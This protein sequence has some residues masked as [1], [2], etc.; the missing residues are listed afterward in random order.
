MKY[1]LYTLAIALMILVVSCEKE[2]KNEDTNAKPT[3]GDGVTDIDGNV[4]ESVII[5]NQEWMAQNLATTR[6][7]DGTPISNIEEQ[8]EWLTTKQPAY[9]WY[10]NDKEKYKNPYGAL[11]NSFV[12][13]T[14]KI[15]PEG[16]HVPSDS[17][18]KNMETAIGMDPDKADGDRYRGGDLE[19]AYKLKANETNE[20]GFS[21]YLAGWRV[22]NEKEFGDFLSY[23]YETSWWTST[24]SYFY[25]SNNNYILVSTQWF[26]QLNDISSGIGRWHTDKNYGFSVRCIKD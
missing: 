17:E 24:D 2:N 10:D 21:A 12:V 8:E 7:N 5:G 15:C 13:E 4:Y 3:Y 22:G 16:W 18:W 11:Y 1:S 6:L 25:D 19:I 14:E 26:R 23:D 9:C 20:T